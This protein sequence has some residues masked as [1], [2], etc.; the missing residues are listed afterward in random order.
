[1][2]AGGCCWMLRR[3]LALQYSPVV[4]LLLRLL[5]DVV[6]GCCCCC[7]WPRIGVVLAD[8][9]TGRQAMG[10]ITPWPCQMSRERDKKSCHQ[11]FFWFWLLLSRWPSEQQQMDR[12]FCSKANMR[13]RDGFPRCNQLISIL[14]W[15]TTTNANCHYHLHCKKY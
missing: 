10:L 1:M 5:G 15:P 6:G 3:S 14:I 4:R 8:E 7:R 13:S 2:L 12:E 9:T 11:L